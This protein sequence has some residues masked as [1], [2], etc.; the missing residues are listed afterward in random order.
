[1]G[2]S[3]NFGNAD[4]NITKNLN[5]GTYFIRVPTV[6][7]IEATYNLQL[8][9]RPLPGS[10]AG[11]TQYQALDLGRLAKTKSVSDRVA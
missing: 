6:N 8:T 10:G 1:M 4:E 3:K 5:R 9:G 7:G 11:S 2:A